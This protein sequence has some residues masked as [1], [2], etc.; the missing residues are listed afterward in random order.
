MVKMSVLPNLIYRLQSKSQQVILW[1]S[2]DS[3]AY[4]ERQKTQNSQLNI[5]V[6]GQSQ[7]NDTTQI[8][9]LL[10]SYINQDSVVWAKEQTTKHNGT[11]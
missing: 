2:P 9:D 11:E 6:K 8:Q 5:E 10:Q 7:R 4:M 1:I 3:K